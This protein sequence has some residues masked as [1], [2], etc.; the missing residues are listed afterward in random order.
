MF[1]IYN[2]N[3]GARIAYYRL[4]NFKNHLS[5]NAYSAVGLLLG[6]YSN[7]FFTNCLPSSLTYFHCSSQNE[8]VPKRMLSI[9]ASSV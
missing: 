4:E 9:K 8:K 3:T 2:Y 5:D 7:N 6:S 1:S